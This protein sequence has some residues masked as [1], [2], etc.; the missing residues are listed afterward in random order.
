M[1]S[2]S[3]HTP[4]RELRHIQVHSE[5]DFLGRYMVSSIRGVVTTLDYLWAFIAAG[6]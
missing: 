2:L 4:E 5:F 6:W 1:T 3:V